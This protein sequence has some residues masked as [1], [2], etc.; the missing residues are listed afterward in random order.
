M[1][2]P[3]PTAIFHI[4]AI[5]NLPAIAGSGQ[6]LSKNLLAAQQI[7]SASIA[8]EQIQQRRSSTVV[9]IP[10]GGNLHDYV[11]FHFAP[12]SPMLNTINRGNVPG[13]EYR[14]DDIVHLVSTAQA[15]ATFPLPFVFTDYHA[16]MQMA[17]FY[18]DLQDLGAIDWPLFFEAPLSGGY[19][20]YW[21]N[22]SS[23]VRYATRMETRQAEFLV[24]DVVPLALIPQIGVRSQAMAQ[25]VQAALKNSLW[26]PNIQ[27]N[28][29]WYY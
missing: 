1:P 19:C 9:S 14:Q 12:R 23:V 16:V 13:C 21:H 25:R 15:V 22:P 17:A 10:P 29:G 4:T 27:I 24:R 7:V 5:D 20:K 8:Y 6:L 2:A 18:G 26:Q 28:P 11:P 3:V